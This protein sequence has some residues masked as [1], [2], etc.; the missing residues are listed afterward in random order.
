MKGKIMQSK[1]ILIALD[2]YY[3]EQKSNSS[4]RE[5]ASAVADDFEIHSATTLSDGKQVA[6]KLCSDENERE[7][8]KAVLLDMELEKGIRQGDDYIAFLRDELRLGV[9]ILIISGY[10]LNEMNDDTHKPAPHNGRFDDEDGETPA[11]GFFANCF[12]FFTL[13]LEEAIEKLEN[14]R[15]DGF[16]SPLSENEIEEIISQNSDYFHRINIQKARALREEICYPFEQ[17]LSVLQNPELLKK[18]AFRNYLVNLSEH[19]TESKRATEKLVDL[20]NPDGLKYRREQVDELLSIYDNPLL[21]DFV[22]ALKSKNAEEFP[23]SNQRETE[24]MTNLIFNELMP[25]VENTVN[26]VKGDA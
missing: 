21:N 16:P 20:P 11:T 10:S 14:L 19:L 18:P 12:Y 13:F 17:I 2:D 24:A 4:I 8:I 26:F 15:D 3:D 7:R 23:D 9:P 25:E 22:D 5:L 6:R 1:P